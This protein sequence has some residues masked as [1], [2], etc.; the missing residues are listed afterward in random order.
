MA[1][2]KCRASAAKKKS[3]T[4]KRRSVVSDYVPENPF[5]DPPEYLP[6]DFCGAEVCCC[7]PCEI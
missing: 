7:P 4:A 3:P 2:K 1:K 5:I 6:C